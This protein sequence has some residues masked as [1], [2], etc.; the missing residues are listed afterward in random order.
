MNDAL[1]MDDDVDTIHFDAEQ[2]ARFDHLQALIEERS[3]IDGDLPAHD[4][5]GMFEG[6][7]D[8]DLRE[9]FLWRAAE[10]STRS[11]EQQPAHRF[12]RFAIK[13]LEN[14]GVFAID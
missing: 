4:P 2:P 12:N 14:C 6:A 10:W 11:S 7:F 1:R 3:G 5:R 13:A 9:F 8:G